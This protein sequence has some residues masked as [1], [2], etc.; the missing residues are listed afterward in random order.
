MKRYQVYL[1]PHSVGILDEFA[2]ISNFTR[3]RLLQEIVDGAASRVAN[4]LAVF[5]PHKEMNY[6]S[7]DS[8]VGVLHVSDKKKH[9]ISQRVDD[10]YYDQWKPSLIPVPG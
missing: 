3:S 4:V 10:I 2:E 8:F 6:S 9:N 5:K 7:I 1:N